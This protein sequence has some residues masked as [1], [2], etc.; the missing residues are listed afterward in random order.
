MDMSHGADSQGNAYGTESTDAVRAG[1]WRVALET[2]KVDDLIV[3]L[4]ETVGRGLSMCCVSFLSLDEGREN[5][6]VA[7]QWCRDGSLRS[8]GE[9]FPASLFEGTLGETHVALSLGDGPA[10]SRRLGEA[11]LSRFGMRAGILVPF[12]APDRPDGFVTAGTVAADRRFGSPEIDLLIELTRVIHLRSAQLLAERALRASEE[13]ARVL[14][15]ATTEVAMLFSPEG[16]IVAANESAASRFGFTPEEFV[17]QCPFDLTSKEVSE[18]RWKV[19][20]GAVA[21]KR[22]CVSRMRIEG[23]TSTTPC[24]RFSMTRAMC[25]SWR[26][27][28]KTSPSTSGTRRI[29]ARRR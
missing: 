4:L 12:G 25:G 16:K 21:D 29:Y 5:L 1:L 2:E 6:R 20:R 8:P 9:V 7:E 26:S 27:S 10:S 18:R 22:P 11:I 19:F 24:T 3:L 13:K 15:N 14:L 28:R 23:G 17:G